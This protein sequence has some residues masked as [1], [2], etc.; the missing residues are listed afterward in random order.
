MKRPWYV[1]PL[2]VGALVIVLI[3]AC[4]WAVLSSPS[5]RLL[6]GTLST[7]HDPVRGVTCY[8]TSATSGI[9]CIPDSDGGR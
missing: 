2:L 8:W 4:A 3:G 7:A 6:D 9:S 1:G 5:P